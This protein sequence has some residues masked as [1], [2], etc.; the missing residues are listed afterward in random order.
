MTTSVNATPLAAAEPET[1]AA[2]RPV[3]SRSE[4]YAA[5]G[6]RMRQGK[7]LVVSGFAITIAGIVGYCL[8]CFSAGVSEDVGATFMSTPGLLIAPTLAV[9]GLGTLFWL[10]GSFVYLSGAM[11]SDPS[12]P[13]LY[14]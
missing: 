13:D 5:A 2:P 7:R 12:G 3:V 11:D 6:H 9:I 10:V 1:E 4:V 8:A 14:F